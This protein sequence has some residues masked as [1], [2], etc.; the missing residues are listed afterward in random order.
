ML[1]TKMYS[2]IKVGGF[3]VGIAS[4]LLIALFIRDELN[5]DLHYQRG[6]HIYRLVNDYQGSDYT[7]KWNYLQPTLKPILEESFPD[8]RQVGRLVVREWRDAGHAQFRRADKKKSVLESRLVYADPEMVEILELEMI[9]GDAFQSLDA[10]RRILLSKE[11]ADK[12]FPD[13]NPVGQKV[14]L[15]EN[16]EG[17][18]VGGVYQNLPDNSHLKA[19]FI[20]T[21][22]NFEFW[23][24]EQTD[25]CCA[26]YDYYVRTQEDV[27][28]HELEEKLLLI[29]DEFLRKEA[30]KNGSAGIEDR[31]QNFSYYLQ[32]V[33]NIYLNPE[34]VEDDFAHGDMKTIWV[35]ALI[36]L[37][38]LVLACVNFINLSTAK[39][40]HRAR[41]VGLRKVMG[42]YRMSIMTQYLTE[43]VLYSLMAVGLGVI[44]A[45][46]ALPAFNQLAMKEMT[47]PLA[48]AWFLLVIL[49][50]ALVIGVLA[51]IYPA[52]YLSRFKPIDTFRGRQGLGM[53][54]SRL[55]SGLVVFQFAA[56]IVLIIGTLVNYQQMQFI[57]NKKLGFDKSQILNLSGMDAINGPERKLLISE[58]KQLSQVQGV[59]LSSYLPVADSEIN[60]HSFWIAGREKLD[61]SIEARVW[62]VDHEYLDV[63]GMTLKEGRNFIANQKSDSASIIINQRMVENLGLTDPLNQRI[64]KGGQQ[65]N[66][67]GVVEDFHF[68]SL[69]NDIG[70]LCML[71]TDFGSTLSI[72]LNTAEVSKTLDAVIEVWE[73]VRPN[74]AI[75]FKFFDDRYA[76][77]YADVERTGHVFLL[78]TILAIVVACSGLFA[79]CAFM[80]EHRAREISIR[81]VL[82]AGALTILELITKEFVLLLLLAGLVALPTGYWLMEEWLASYVH[83]VSIGWDVF[84][85]AAFTVTVV[86]VITI[87]TQSI[88]A[89]MA[90][91]V[92]NLK[93]E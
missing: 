62:Q 46:L 34:G 92:D 61:P 51:G 64:S 1:R 4:C 83:R 36:A 33:R 78:F 66:V 6:Q 74:Q 11:K 2:T 47:L 37:I 24:G 69:Q 28:K 40:A 18:E 20:L 76:Q 21:L 84:V 7:G 81:K 39:S 12:Y 27:D 55:R 53:K 43:S 9:Y 91:P 88:K 3:A 35:F 19:D 54:S 89:A 70:A 49:L 68:E 42:S 5:Y 44:L 8:I 48:E 38:V 86:L 82:G 23:Q 60:N 16:L 90:N 93:D 22:K 85:I 32:P 65:Y 15:N 10:P 72:K 80:V 26:N 17:Y 87:S 25:W 79:L 77:T 59:T 30:L 52:V 58:L 45:A 56:S 63:Y 50:S 14:I 73:R 41:E 13:Q 31:I 67:I 71:V 57:L 29:R 75:Q